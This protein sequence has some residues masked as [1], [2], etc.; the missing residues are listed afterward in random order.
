M[1]GSLV[2]LYGRQALRCPWRGALRLARFNTVID[3]LEPPAW[4][5]NYFTGVP[6]PAGAGLVLLP[7]IL[8][9]QIDSPLLRSPVL[10]G[11]VI[12]TVAFL[13]VS[14]MPTY[15]FKNFRVQHR[16]VLFTMLGVGIL[17]ALSV[18]APWLTLTII[19]AAYILSFPAAIRSFK[20]LEIEADA[21][22]KQDE[23]PGTFAGQG[24]GNDNQAAE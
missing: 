3:A 10:V 17:A 16:M 21:F 2:P 12:I 22:Q 11:I 14:R 13:L 9:F 1:L 20:R 15:S 7:L 18:T 23:V 8:S 5:K 19:L 4:A 24:E 6:A